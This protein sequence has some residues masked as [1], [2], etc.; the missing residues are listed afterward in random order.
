MHAT[1][2]DVNDDYANEMA[3][4]DRTKG[5]YVLD[6]AGIDINFSLEVQQQ[7]H[8]ALGDYLESIS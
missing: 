4:V 1:D 7:I 3:G 8:E 5:L 2:V 6:A